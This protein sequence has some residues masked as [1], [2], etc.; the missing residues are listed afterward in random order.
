MN[1][2]YERVKNRLEVRTEALNLQQS[3]SQTFNVE[4]FDTN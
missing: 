1:W 4:Y 2:K 3:L